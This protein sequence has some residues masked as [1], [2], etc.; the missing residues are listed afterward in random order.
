MLEQA[1]HKSLAEISLLVIAAH[2]ALILWI[3]FAPSSLH[4]PQ[5]PAERLVVK[6]IQL[7]P[8]QAQKPKA[9]SPI[10][11]QERTPVKVEDPQKL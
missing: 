2:L 1:S 10:I 3:I 5:K 6:T 9:P 4:K 11:K 8:V 7:N